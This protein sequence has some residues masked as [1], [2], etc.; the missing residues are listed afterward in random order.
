MKL[1]KMSILFICLILFSCDSDDDSEQVSLP[2]QG[3]IALALSN[4]GG[5]V[6]EN[7][8]ALISNFYG[9]SINTA[10][11][12]ISGTAGLSGSIV[13]NIIDDDDSFR[14][15]VNENSFPIGDPSLS[16]F[17]TVDYQSDNFNLN[18]A[19]GTLEILSYEE[20]SDQN[21]AKLSATFSV[22]GNNF[23]TITS[24]IRDIILV[25]QNC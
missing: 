13:I 15:L 16:F 19:A 12:I 9:S 18:A 2:D 1:L 17:A 21:Y 3:N 14:A 10:D 11:I 5:F 7:I 20:F 24:T 4:G 25:C 23:N 22:A 6:V 8:E